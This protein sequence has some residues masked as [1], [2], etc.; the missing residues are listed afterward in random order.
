MHVIHDMR[1]ARQLSREFPLRARLSLKRRPARLV[2]DNAS[3][4]F[5]CIL[6]LAGP[7]NP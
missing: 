1:G 7:L 2:S 5:S 6:Y 3:C 4:D